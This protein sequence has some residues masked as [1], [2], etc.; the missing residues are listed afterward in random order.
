MFVDVNV[1]E[2]YKVGVR[3]MEGSVV[4]CLEGVGRSVL[5]R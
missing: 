4:L 5:R 1:V 3:E 2:N